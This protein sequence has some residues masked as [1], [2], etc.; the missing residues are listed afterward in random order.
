MAAQLSTKDTEFLTHAQTY[1][2]FTLGVKWVVIH[3]ATI[4]VFATVWFA[5]PGGFLGGLFVGA[6]VLALGVWAMNHGLAH[7]TERDNPGSP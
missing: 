3:L 5:T 6:V 4:I 7:S 2:R 1:H